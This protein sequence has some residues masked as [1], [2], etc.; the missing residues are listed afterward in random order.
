MSLPMID[1]PRVP[2]GSAAVPCCL[3]LLP[4]QPLQRRWPGSA[5]LP[6]NPSGFSKC[7][8]LQATS[9]LPQGPR[10]QQSP[11][12]GLDS[13]LIWSTAKPLFCSRCQPA[14]SG[15]FAFQLRLRSHRTV[16]FHLNQQHSGCRSQPCGFGDH[17]PQLP[18]MPFA[19]AVLP[20]HKPAA[21]KRIVAKVN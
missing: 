12:L 16:Q 15:A 14:R 2:A 8:A 10:Q 1:L 17:Q 6:E 20:S 19:G 7:I 21:Q 11:S 9:P 13:V 3:G 18:K 5:L 4:T